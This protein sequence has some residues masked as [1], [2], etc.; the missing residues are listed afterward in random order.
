MVKLTVVPVIPLTIE[1]D[2]PADLVIDAAGRR[3]PID[4]WLKNILGR[5]ADLQADSSS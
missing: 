4:Q 1:G 2:L 5:P 3:S